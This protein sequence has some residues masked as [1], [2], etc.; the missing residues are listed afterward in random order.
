MIKAE[1]SPQ[2]WTNAGGKKSQ[3]VAQ[4][5]Q[6]WNK[7]QNQPESCG[8]SE[9]C[10]LVRCWVC[11]NRTRCGS[12]DRWGH[13][14]H[15]HLYIQLHWESN[16]TLSRF[17]CRKWTIRYCELCC[18]CELL[19]WTHKKIGKIFILIIFPYFVQFPPTSKLTGSY[20]SERLKIITCSL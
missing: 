4:T 20:Q 2:T 19:N 9:C 11:L 6:K 17:T 12:L 7:E 18:S 10:L 8:L 16:L 3:K 13:R 1:G 14:N 5:M 15:L